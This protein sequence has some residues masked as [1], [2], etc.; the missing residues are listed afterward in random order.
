M[1][2]YKIKDYKI[3]KKFFSLIKFLLKSPTKA[4]FPEIPAEIYSYSRGL[5][6]DNLRSI[7]IPS[8]LFQE[9]REILR[10]YGVYGD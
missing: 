1:L 4:I 5:G 2:Y 9:L 6:N 10:E 8:P 7:S 3:K